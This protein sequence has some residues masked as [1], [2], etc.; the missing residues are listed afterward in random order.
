M[1]REKNR[2][3]IL[4]NEQ[5]FQKLF[6]IIVERWMAGTYNE[7]GV[8]TFAE[9]LAR[10][11]DGIHTLLDKSE[12]G[13]QV[14]IFTSGGVISAGMQMSL[15]LSSARAIRLGWRI[16]N[17]SVTLLSGLREPTKPKSRNGALEMDLLLFN[18]TAHLDLEPEAKLITYR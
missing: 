4:A 12:P 7:E 14:A 10:V 18:S 3:N 1:P 8:E 13:Q 15:G 2:N 17:S 9:F 11:K 6:A 16:R 5:H